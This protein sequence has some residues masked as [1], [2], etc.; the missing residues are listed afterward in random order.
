MRLTNT[1]RGYIM[2]MRDTHRGYIVTLKI[3]KRIMN[4]G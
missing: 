4:I 2:E 1:H 3:E